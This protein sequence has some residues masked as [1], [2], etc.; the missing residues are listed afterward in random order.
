[1]VSSSSLNSTANMTTW[2]YDENHDDVRL[3]VISR[4]MVNKTASMHRDSL[5][6]PYSQLPPYYGLS[7]AIT[8]M[9]IYNLCKTIEEDEDGDQWLFDDECYTIFKWLERLEEATG[10]SHDHGLHECEFK[11]GQLG[12]TMVISCSDKPETVPRPAKRIQSL[13]DF[14]RVTKEPVVRRFN[15]P[16]MYF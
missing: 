15:Q 3:M 11:D 10:I 1:M 16:R 14:L 13:K 4:G 8:Y 5:G 12:L 9:N 2:T 7:Y 6:M